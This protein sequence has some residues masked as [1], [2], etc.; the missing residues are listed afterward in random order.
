MSNHASPF[1]IR[2]YLQTYLFGFDSSWPTQSYKEALPA[3]VSLSD[4]EDNLAIPQALPTGMERKP[5]RL[6]KLL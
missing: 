6:K 5:S 3:I 4:S 1:L 2:R